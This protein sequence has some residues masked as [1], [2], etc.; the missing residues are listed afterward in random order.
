[1]ADE[2]RK[3]A[4]DADEEDSDAELS[5]SG[6]DTSPPLNLP[7]HPNDDSDGL[8]Q[9]MAQHF[10][11]YA[12]YVIKDRAIPDVDDGLKPV[13]RRILHSLHDKEDG[14]FH[15]VAN[16]IGHTMQYHPHGDASIGSALVVL[17]CKEYFIDRQ[18]NFGN[19][20]T[21]DP[22]SAARY[23]ECRLTP[24][25]R[26][27]LF[28]P[29][30][31]EFVDSYDGRNREPV[32]LPAKV[33]GLLLLGAEGIAVGMTTRI[34]PHNFNELLQAQIAILRNRPFRLYPDFQQGG[35]MDVSEYDDGRGRIVLRALIE[36][37]SDKRLAIRQIPATTTTES[38]I[39]SIEEAARRNKIK[40]AG[41][42]DYTA[43]DVE[44]E[45]LLPRGVYADETIKQLYA[46]T[47]CQVSVPSTIMVIRDNAPVEMTVSEVLRRNTDKLLFYLRRELEIEQGKLQERFHEKTL[48]QLFIEHR[49]YKRIEE[50]ETYE[51]VVAEVRSGLD[52]FRNQL[53]RDV[54]DEDIDKLLQIQIRRIS[55]FDMGKNREDLAKIV[56]DLKQARHHLRHLV[57]YAVAY[58]EGLLSRYGSQFPRR[59]R[60]TD[61]EQVDARDVALRN[62]KVGHDRVNHFV[63]SEVRN[64][65][66][67][68]APLLCS[69]FDRLLLLRNDG[70][71]QVI[72]IPA[73]QYVGPVKYLLRA[74]R[75]QVYSV[76]YRDRR[77]NAYYAKRFRID[78]YIMDKEY[79]A[80][81]KNCLIEALY[82]NRGVVLDLVLTPN[83]RRS[84]ESVRVAFD[85][86]EVRSATARGFKV[87]GYPVEGVT[88]V[89]R[90]VPQTE[91]PES[92]AEGAGE[93]SPAP[94]G[95]EAHAD[96]DDGAA[97]AP[98]SAPS[99]AVGA[100]A[101][102]APGRGTADPEEDPGTPPPRAA[103]RRSRAATG[104]PAEED[105]GTPGEVASVGAGT[106]APVPATP[107]APTA[108]VR[109]PSTKGKPPARATTPVRAAAPEP[110][111][112]GPPQRARRGA[113]PEQRANAPEPPSR[114]HAAAAGARGTARR[115]GTEAKPAAGKDAKHDD[116]RK[117][118]DEETPFFLE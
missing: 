34:M 109:A 69:E 62:V 38:L 7:D 49:I 97:Q 43:E 26:E 55:R 75:E 40:I 82:L 102:T 50:A 104:V 115:A 108:A 68:D 24:L 45:V 52:P 30:I 41:I 96:N 93:A 111:P 106:P 87:T 73:K 31:T 20:L 70:G 95:A 25:A 85:E 103:P 6:G 80:L 57:E 32:T 46:Y 1:M 105:P 22:A 4:D 16:I 66:K 83:S 35:L 23:I 77:S 39:A 48:V 112:A 51:A 56:E 101:E 27:V 21:G 60:I 53:K 67:T 76:L 81:P 65:S 84:V 91:E 117:L 98:L 28:N 118:I 64:S 13:Q 47:D 29:E 110:L 72:P 100:I 88:L 99:P 116:A 9:L 10:V 2:P 5:S 15:K 12:S 42:S 19:V 3:P 44:I 61:L 33:P 37:D 63:G 58:L 90:G 94:P 107:R 113:A 114:R 14:R 71:Y 11:E 79:A 36:P 8:R 18:G 89:D 78:R 17:A 92:P 59:T 74:D 54:T 86:V